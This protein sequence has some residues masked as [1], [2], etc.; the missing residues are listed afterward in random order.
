MSI[1]RQIKQMLEELKEEHDIENLATFSDLDISE[2]LKQND[3][4]IVRYKEFYFNELQRYEELQE[5]MDLLK[6]L[7]YK[8][9]KFEDDREWQKKEIEEYC[10]PSDKAI[11]RMQNILAKQM[12]RVRF[13]ET[14]WKAFDKMGW[15]MKTFSD[16]EMRGL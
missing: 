14:C 13:F 6:G 12:A 7:R 16:R 1:N 4:M 3:M 2:K 5:K 15:S 8:Y 11:I 10:F 9:Y